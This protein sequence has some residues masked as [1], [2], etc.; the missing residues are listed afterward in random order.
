[1]LR[2]SNSKYIKIRNTKHLSAKHLDRIEDKFKVL[3]GN[4]AYV[5]MILADDSSKQAKWVPIKISN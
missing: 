4:I 2:L 5:Q 3:I 1:M